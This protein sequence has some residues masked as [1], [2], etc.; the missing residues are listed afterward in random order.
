[1]HSINSSDAMPCYIIYN[2]SNNNKNN[3]NNN[4]YD[5]NKNSDNNN[6]LFLYVCFKAKMIRC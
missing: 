1:M 5:N 6:K 2:N 4:N 3:D